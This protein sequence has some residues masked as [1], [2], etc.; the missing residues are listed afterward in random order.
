MEIKKQITRLKSQIFRLKKFN[1][2]IG[3]AAGVI[4]LGWGLSVFIFSQEDS[5]VR[6]AA[7]EIEE[8]AA[9]IR[10]YYQNRPDYWGL[11]TQIVL[12]K[13]IYPNRM[14]KNSSLNGY[15]GNSVLVGNGINGEVLMPGSRNFDII[16]KG[17]NKKQCV[18]L[19]SFK[20]DQKFWLGVTGVS[21][22][23]NKGGQQLFGWNDEKNQLPV[24]KE[25]AETV[26]ES[27]NTII[28]HCEQ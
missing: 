25:Q 9:N 19:A 2:L 7:A 4:L 10:R 1:K 3:A 24:K 13:N 27:D 18:G 17:L 28:W 15:F 12:D 6:E 16:Y 14:L 23:N 5:G 20:F 22:V 26:C 11:N 21:V 8:L